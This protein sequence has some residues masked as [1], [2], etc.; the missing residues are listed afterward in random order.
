MT[1]TG[2]AAN[3]IVAEK[4]MRI[5]PDMEISFFVH[6]RVCFWITLLSCAIGGVMLYGIA[7]L[8]NYFGSNW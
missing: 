1:I 8:D 7:S 2:S 3:I 6:Y 5:D 4:A